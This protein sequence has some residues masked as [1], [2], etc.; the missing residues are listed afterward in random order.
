MFSKLNGQKEFHKK[1]FYVAS[2][3]AGTR[4]EVQNVQSNVIGL[5]TLLKNCIY[6]Y[7]LGRFS[8]FNNQRVFWLYIEVWRLNSTA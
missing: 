1:H 8:T 6:F 2:L 5:W 4:D 7:L 3:A